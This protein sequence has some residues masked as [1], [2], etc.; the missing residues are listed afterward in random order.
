VG[1]GIFAYGVTQALAPLPSPAKVHASL[2]RILAYW[3]VAFFLSV[4]KK[5]YTIN[6]DYIYF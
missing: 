4:I 1:A 3:T 2:S 6:L 5:I